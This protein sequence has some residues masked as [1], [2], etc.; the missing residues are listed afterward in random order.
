V[1]TGGVLVAGWEAEPGSFENNIDRGAVTRTLLHNIY[2]R[3]VERNIAIQADLPPLVPGLATEWTVSPDA[4]TYTFTL[5]EG[6]KF[7]DGTPFD[8]EAVKFNIER[9]SDPSHP[10]YHQAGAGSTALGYGN[11]ASVDVINAN[12]VRVV[13]KEPF[14][15]FLT[16][17]A[18]GTYS[19]AS[20]A[21]IER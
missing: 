15:D 20:P 6:V 7:H 21:A 5:R 19:I 1:T 10:F 17:L 11:L 14:A 16:V 3:L 4:T 9:N 18:F 8:A 13:H 12:T 2:D